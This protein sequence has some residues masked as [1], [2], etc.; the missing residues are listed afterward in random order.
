M[1]RSTCGVANFG[2]KSIDRLIVGGVGGAGAG[3][4]DG[5]HYFAVG[6]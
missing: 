4:V 6:S 3:A 2:D 1:A 5:K